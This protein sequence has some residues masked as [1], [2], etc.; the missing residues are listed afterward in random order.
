V[1][2]DL[3]G[4]AATD[5]A[6]G[7]F[8]GALLVLDGASGDV[9]TRLQFGLEAHEGYSRDPRLPRFLRDIVASTG[10]PISEILVCDVDGRPGKDLVFGS[11]D[12][13]VYAASPRTDETLWRFDSESEVYDRCIPLRAAGEPLLLAWDVEATYLLKASDGTLVGRLPLAGGAAA[14]A[15]GDVNGDG[16][17]DIVAVGHPSRTVHAWST[18]LPAGG[19]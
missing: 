11:S 3:T 4:G 18:G 2:V 17:L 16:I 9:L 15:A 1:A 13:Y 5:V 7:C 10:E 19:S 8:A 6:I 14:V 12:G